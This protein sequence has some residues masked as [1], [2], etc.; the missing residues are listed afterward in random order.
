M[1]WIERHGL[2]SLA[3][4][5]AGSLAAEPGLPAPGV[6]ERVLDRLRRN[7]AQNLYS[8]ARFQAVVDALEG[9]PVCP[10][11]GIH[12][13]DTVYREDPEAR[14][15]RDLDLL[16][17]P[18]RIEEAVRRLRSLGLEETPLSRE[19]RDVSPER[20]LTDGRLPVELHTRLGVKHGARSWWEVL[21]PG[22][23]QVH[24]REVF[25]LDRETTLVHLVS[26]LVK[27]RPFSRLAWVEDVLRWIRLGVDAGRACAR[28][29]E[30]GALRSFAAGI[31]I[32]ERTL[33]PV[34]LRAAAAEPLRAGD[35]L[36]IVLNERL[37]WRDL[38][39]DPWSAGP[40]TPLG[41]TLSV[42]LLADRPGD[43]GSFLR[44]KLVERRRAGRR[45]ERN[46]GIR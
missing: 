34:G 37:V 15:L 31:G 1:A 17:P 3:G 28:A 12:L 19:I 39:R 2:L 7:A 4:G 14:V 20:V 42:F 36:A 22:P 24:G 33:G 43:M 26:H 18:E 32:L 23:G 25:T 9:I 46:R 41:R 21:R 5:R 27:H 16:L 35:R 40:G 8:V 13:L 44:A 6:H 45:R 10:L 29:R 11:K 38:L 30:L